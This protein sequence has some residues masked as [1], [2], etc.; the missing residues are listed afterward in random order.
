MPA[1]KN[2]VG[3]EFVNLTVVSRVGSV[4]PT[5]WLC[6]CYCGGTTKVRACHLISGHTTS[7]GCY[8]MTGEKNS[9][10]KHGLSNT[11]EHSTWQDMKK[12]CHNEKSK[13][14]HN[15]G[16]RGIKVCDRWLNSFENFYTDMGKKPN[17]SYTIERIDNN[18]GYSPENC[19]WA[20]RTEQAHNKRLAKSN[21]TGVQG[22]RWSSQKNQWQTYISVNNKRIN[23][24][25]HNDFFEACCSRKSAENKYWYSL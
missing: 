20:T 11:S 4:S 24:G 14:F 12:R 15:Y 16:G 13:S 22:V 3:Q 23:L 25:F 9:Y 6:E 18:K 1:F 10:Y 8:R 5:Q 7:C 17:P 2:L 19:K 21:K